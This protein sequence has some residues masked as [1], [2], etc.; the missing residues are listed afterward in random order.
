MKRTCPGCGGNQRS[1][2]KWGEVRKWICKLC[3]RKD[4]VG[5]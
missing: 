1:K 5:N 3:G 4:V 2:Q